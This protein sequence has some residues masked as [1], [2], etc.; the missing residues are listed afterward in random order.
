MHVFWFKCSFQRRHI[1][2]QMVRNRSF[3]ILIRTNVLYPLMN[4]LN[5]VINTLFFQIRKISKVHKNH[6]SWSYFCHFSWSS[7]IVYSIPQLYDDFKNCNM[8]LH[9]AIWVKYEVIVWNA[10]ETVPETE[11]R[12]L[13]RKLPVALWY[14]GTNWI[15][16][17]ETVSKWAK[18]V[19]WKG[20]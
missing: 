14:P 11:N 5:W 13:D 20:C 18:G 16:A 9:K 6:Y 1:A 7:K 8:N 2:V 10:F 12:T 17:I 3:F 15:T 4:D 19:V